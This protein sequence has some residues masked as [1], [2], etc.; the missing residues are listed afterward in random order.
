VQQLSLPASLPAPQSVRPAPLL[1]QLC[2]GGL[3]THAPLTQKGVDA[4]QPTRTLQVPASS[5]VATPLPAHC[6]APCV[7]PQFDVHEQPPHWHA[8]VHVC[9]DPE[10]P[11]DR[12]AP[13]AHAPSP[14]QVPPCHTPPS[15][16]VCALVPQLP[17]TT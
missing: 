13:A 3:E 1:A 11:H 15:P 6:V 4:P 14:A 8:V 10:V 16:H 9:D 7:H 12:V 17:Q 5:H 2:G